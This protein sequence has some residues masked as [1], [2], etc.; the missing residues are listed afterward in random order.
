M[1][2]S[3]RKPLRK[4]KK[5][6]GK[7]KRVSTAAKSDRQRHDVK[8]ELVRMTDAV[9]RKFHNLKQE[10]DSM[11]QYFEQ[12]AKPLVIPLKQQLVASVRD[13]K[14]EPLDTPPATTLKTETND[15]DVQTDPG[16][17]VSTQTE[18][19][20]VSSYIHKLSSY[21]KD[22]LDHVY[23]VRAD[24]TGGMAIGDSKI[25]FTTTRVYVKGKQ[26]DATP[27][28][29]ELLFMQV[30][31]TDFIGK[32]DLRNYKEIL[33]LTNAHRQQYSA[34]KPVNTNRGKKY[35][36][37]ISVILKPEGDTVGSG[38][39]SLMTVAYD[40]VNEVVNRL[41]ILVLSKGAGHSGHD[42]EIDYLTDM[43]RTNGVIA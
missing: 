13:I 18:P 23:G 1:G 41:R 34:E 15:V 43:L 20:L 8:A 40:D 37:V 17:D 31:K 14:K 4:K 16:V 2:V 39:P 28:L 10:S 12:S 25:T 3:Q 24:G 33:F 38:L 5:V 9:K 36:N 27:G 11:Q 29:M 30:P 42:G 7:N 22:K 32:D 21:G 26:F 35:V 6:K 19:S